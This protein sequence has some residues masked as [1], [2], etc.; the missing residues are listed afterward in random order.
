MERGS[1]LGYDLNEKYCQ[2]SYYSETREEPETLKISPDNC[3]IPLSLGKMD[4]QWVYGME[5]ECLKAVDESLF[6]ENLFENSITGKLQWGRRFMMRY[7]FWQ[8]S[9]NLLWNSL[10]R[11]NI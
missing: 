9:S 8:N 10:K 1:I 11:L 4:G 6:V 5:A 3:Q 2:I 7:G